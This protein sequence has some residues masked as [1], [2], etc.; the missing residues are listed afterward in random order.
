ML[1]KSLQSGDPIFEKVSR[2][3]YLALR[4]IVL[5]GSGPR[6]R[7]LAETALQQVGVVM[8]TDKV[9]L[10]A[11]ELI[12]AASVSVSVHGPWWYVNLCDNMR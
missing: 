8:L 3:V 5:G 2:V 4:G 6:G 10:V 1:A 7:K 12:M 11:E 9:V